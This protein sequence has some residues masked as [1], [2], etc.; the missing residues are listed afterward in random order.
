MER[1]AASG[2]SPL[3]RGTHHVAR[4]RR[5]EARFIPAR[6]GN[7]PR[8]RCRATPTAVHPRSRGEHRKSM[9][10]E[11][12]SSGSSPLARGT[13][14]RGRDAADARRFIPARAGNTPWAARRSRCNAVHPRSRGEHVIY[15]TLS[16]QSDGSS[17]LAR[18]TLQR[19]AGL[20]HPDR[21]IPARAG[22]TETSHRPPSSRTVHPRSR[23]EHG[24]VGHAMNGSIGSSPLA[25]GTRTV[26]RA[27][28]AS[29]R[30]IPARAGNTRATPC[31]STPT[32]VHPRSRGEHRP[33]A[34]HVVGSFGSSPL[35]RGTRHE[36]ATPP[37][38]VRFIPA[39]AGNT[40]GTV[41]P[42][43][44]EA[45]HPRSRGEHA[46]IRGA[47]IRVAG[48]SPLARGTPHHDAA[49]LDRERFIPARAGNTCPARSKRISATV[50]PRSRGEHRDRDSRR[51]KEIG[52]SPLARG[53]PPGAE[54][55]WAR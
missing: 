28:K 27:V 35:A 36:L 18:G 20:A 9:D 53:T 44:R 5:V 33:A 32:T 54:C 1:F 41:E 21:F 34:A 46:F 16:P 26:R 31:M 55:R 8:P 23:G 52:S 40:S 29:E 43:S 48:S 12:Y 49:R 39:R 22:N 37:P 3:A 13:R 6:A 24:F 14:A 2:S 38:R 19:R 25:R 17:P 7:T 42:R 4:R 51:H 30:F 11:S 15:F 45:V 50:H 47:I 10:A